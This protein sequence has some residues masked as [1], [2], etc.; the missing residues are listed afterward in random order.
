MKLILRRKID[1]GFE[2]LGKLF[3]ED[4]FLCY[5]LED[6]YRAI[7]IKHKTRIPAGIYELALRAFGSH[8]V[9]YVKK[10]EDIAHKGMIQIMNVLGFT[11]ILFHIGNS[12][13]D[14]S[15]CILVG[16]DYREED[17]RLYLVNSTVAYKKIYPIIQKMIK[18]GEVS[19]EIIDEED[20]SIEEID[21]LVKGIEQ[22]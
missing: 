17:G 22:D 20:L 6:T 5:T 1:T 3:L 2:T 19:L 8:F 10:F 9:R 4:K 7:K 11:D 15:G 13:K 14:T 18:Y 16:V 12:I 21:T